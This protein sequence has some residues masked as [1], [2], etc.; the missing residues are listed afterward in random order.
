MKKTRLCLLIAVSAWAYIGGPLSVRAAPPKVSHVAS[1]S[2]EYAQSIRTGIDEFD[3]A[4]YPEAR[5]AFTRAHQLYPNAR[6]F[7]GLGFVAFE[8]RNYLD[9]IK[10][11]EAALEATEKPLQGD[12]R[13]TTEGLLARAR[14]LIGRVQLKVTPQPETVLVDGVPTD[15]PSDGA[16]ALQV[17]DHRLE[18]RVTGYFA[19][20]R[21]L[22]IAGGEELTLALTMRKLESTPTPAQAEPL[23]APTSPVPRDASAPRR[24]YKSPWLWTAVAVVLVGAGVGVGLALRPNAEVKSA[25]ATTTDSTPMGGVIYTLRGR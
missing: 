13:Q 3:A 12:L 5:A 14:S 7:R 20:Q 17:G 23:S 25:D 21:E 22:K 16:I 10:Y 19:E 18:V 8:L 4:N 15:I 11:L 24:W 9:C 1:E 2:R 6:T